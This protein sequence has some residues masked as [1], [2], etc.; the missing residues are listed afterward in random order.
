MPLQLKKMWENGKV[1]EMADK[2][3]NDWNWNVFDH[4]EE[5]AIQEAVDEVVSMNAA[6]S[7]GT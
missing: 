7:R 3:M 1:G 2:M 5:E 6:S 4:M